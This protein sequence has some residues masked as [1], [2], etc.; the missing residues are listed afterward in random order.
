MN[1][2]NSSSITTNH[3]VSLFAES[4]SVSGDG[5]DTSVSHLSFAQKQVS[6]PPPPNGLGDHHHTAPP[7]PSTPPLARYI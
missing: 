6:L 4:Q 7:P 3:T 5:H 2:R 1:V